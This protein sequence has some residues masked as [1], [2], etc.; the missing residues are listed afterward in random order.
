[1]VSVGLVCQ[2]VQ[3]WDGGYTLAGMASSG[4]TTEITFIEQSTGLLFCHLFSS[5]FYPFPKFIWIRLYENEE[6]IYSFMKQED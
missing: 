6:L 5:R 3:E 4:R 2:K 1:M